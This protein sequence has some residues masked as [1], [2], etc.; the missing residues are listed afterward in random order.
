MIQSHNSLKEDYEVT[1]LELDTIVSEVLKIDGVI[2]AR[3]TGAGFGGCAVALVHKDSINT[4]T[5]TV[6]NSYFEKIGTEPEFY[7]ATVSKGVH[8]IDKKD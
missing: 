7:I 8:S 5:E 3:M 4:L 1:G 2:G 6:F